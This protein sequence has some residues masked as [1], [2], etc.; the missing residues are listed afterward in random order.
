MNDDEW[1]QLKATGPAIAVDLLRCQWAR[2]L[3]TPEDTEECGEQAVQIVVLYGTPLGIMNL[4]L[5]QR[6]IDRVSEES[7]PHLEPLDSQQPPP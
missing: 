1:L 3:F 2:P 7:I 5:C 6:H 4:K